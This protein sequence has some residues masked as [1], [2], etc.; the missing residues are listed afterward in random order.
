MFASE[1]LCVEKKDEKE[2]MEI[3][4]Q[5]DKEGKEERNVTMIEDDECPLED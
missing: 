3:F 4:V 5:K 2:N 1:T